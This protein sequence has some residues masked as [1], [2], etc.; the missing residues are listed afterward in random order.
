MNNKKLLKL[1]LFL[2]VLIPIKTYALDGDYVIASKI[3]SDMVLDIAGGTAN[4]NANI[5]LFTSHSGLNQKW[6]FVYNEAGYYKILST[7]DN[8]YCLDINSDPYGRKSNV[9]LSTCSESETQHFIVETDSEGYYKIS[10]YDK[11]YVLDIAGAIARNNANIQLY[12]S[13]NNANQRFT[14]NK[15]VEGTKTIENGIYTISSNNNYLNVNSNSADNRVKMNFT[16]ANNTKNQKWKVTYLNN[17][18]YQ[19][20]SVLDKNFSLDIPG[21]K[22][23]PNTYIQLFWNNGGINQQWVIKDNGD[24]TYQIISKTNG[25]NLEASSDVSFVNEMNGT[26]NQKFKFEVT[27]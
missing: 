5:Q 1:L 24:G 23:T 13:H 12:E 22:K 20:S 2:L 27:N 17:G 16:A 26:E 18:T 19:I 14:I 11:Q 6:K 15:D 21:G 3:S 8:N 25:L 4:D 9:K 7:Q 10:S